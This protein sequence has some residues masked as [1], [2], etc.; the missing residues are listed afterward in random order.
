MTY[1]T[2]LI[3]GGAGFLGSYLC[4]YYIEQGANVVCI[5]NLSSG[6]MRNVKQLSNQRKFV[7]VKCDIVNSLPK[8]VTGKK[9][10]LIINM[11]SPASPPHYQRLALETLQVGSIGT[12]HLLQLALENE[13]RFFQAST[14]EVYG[15]PEV[16]PQP[17]S[18]KGSVNSYGPRS[19]YDESKRY[20]EALVYVYRNVYGVDT[21]I[22]R[23]FNTY[24]PRMDPGDGRVVSNFIV[25]ALKDQ[26][27]T[28]YGDGSQTRSFC[29][30][31]DLIKGIV[32]LINSKQEG[33]MNLGNPGEFT[34]SQLANKVLELTGSRSKIS[35]LPL[36]GDDPTQRQPVIAKAKESLGWQPT[37]PLQTGLKKTIEYFKGL[38]A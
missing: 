8:S 33:P 18:Y 29:Y 13:A 17:E 22:A 4:D 38:E 26:S 35:Y 19:M 15:D 6:S 16:H 21:V 20:A 3:A 11:A 34:V 23:F 5:D 30:V 1:K 9:Y 31:D 32:A 2:V 12:E 14:S 36:P 37:I 28:V 7:F 25:Q 27:L 10:D 24:G